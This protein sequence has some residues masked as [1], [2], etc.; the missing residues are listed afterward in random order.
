[1][2]VLQSGRG[3]RLADDGEA[4][5]RWLLGTSAHPVGAGLRCQCMQQSAV[6][7]G[8]RCWGAFAQAGSVRSLLGV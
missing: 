7:V 5:V 1:L 4:L 2:A 3:G 6:D 8:I